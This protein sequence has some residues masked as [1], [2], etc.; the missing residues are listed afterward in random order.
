V[1][2]RLPRDLE[3]IVLK[4]IAKEP[5]RR[6]Q[7]A[8]KMAEDLQR[9]L[10]DRPVQA[11]RSS[12]AEQAWRWGRRNPG[13]AAMAGSVTTLLLIIALGLWVGLVRLEK[14]EGL[15]Q[16]KLYNSL[17]QQALATSRSRR[18]GQRFES[19]AKVAEAAQLARER[20]WLPSKALEL[21]NAALAALAIP[22]IY[23]GRSLA[24]PPLGEG[25]V[26]IDETF[27]LY[28][29]TDPQGNCSIRRVANDLEVHFLTNPAAPPGQ[30][31]IPL[32]I[33]SADGRF[34]VVLYQKGPAQLWQLDG[35]K[36]R[37][38]LAANDV[39]RAFYHPGGGQIAFAYT[40]GSVSVYSL[41]TG[42]EVN[43]FPPDLS[44]HAPRREL[45]LAFHPTKPLLA[46][47]SYFATE[48]QFRNLETG[49]LVRRLDLPARCSWVAW[50]PRGQCLAV[51]DGD[52]AV[53]H[54]YDGTTFQPLRTLSA[55]AGGTKVYF[56][57]AGD[58]LLAGGWDGSLLLYDVP[59]GQ[60]L[61]QHPPIAIYHLR[62]N[63]DDNWLAV[64]NGASRLRLMQVADSREYRTLAFAPPQG[65]LTYGG[66][67]V[68]PA[69]RLLAAGVSPRG[70]P[71]PGLGLWDL[72]T[73]DCLAFLPD[74]GVHGL[75]FEAGP[76]GALLTI[77][78][79][80][81][82]SWPV[83]IDPGEPG[84][85][86]AGSR[87]QVTIGPPARLPLP[88][89]TSL[90][91]SRDGRVLV[92]AA[93]AISGLQAYS[94]AWVVQID[95]PASAQRLEG[96]S[97]IGYAKV[98]PEGHWVVTLWQGGEGMRVWDAANG[99]LIRHLGDGYYP[100]FSPD[101]RWLAAG[102]KD[103][104]LYAVGSW[105]QVGR[106]LRGFSVFSPDA[107]RLAVW[108]L[109]QIIRLVETESGKELA[110][111]EEPN[112]ETPFPVNF[113]P[114]GTRLI[115]VTD[116][117]GR[118]IHVWDLPALR[119]R[120]KKMDLDWDEPERPHRKLGTVPFRLEVLGAEGFARAARAFHH[121]DN[122]HPEPAAAELEKA[123]ALSPQLDW[124]CNQLARLHVLGPKSLRNPEKAV[125]L[126][127]RAIRLC[128]NDI[129]YKNT[130]G[131]AYYRAGRWQSA[132]DTLEASLRD[133]LGWRL[134]Y[135]LFFL[136]MCHHR[137]GDAAKA[138]DCYDRAV[139]WVDERQ[140]RL[141]T[142]WAA[143]LHELR[144]E[145]GALLGVSD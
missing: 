56:N 86:S 119:D 125:A 42:R 95:R 120:L 83:R 84:R 127:E 16:E 90:S 144:Q 54:L 73:G 40:D 135:D 89:G 15:A 139:K 9:F 105:E 62:F 69:G 101:G 142:D 3:T 88:P 45:S 116:G 107:K 50:H 94:G 23:P 17:V 82:F 24:V 60:L 74:V 48:L 99:R 63:R 20:G 22:D 80:G 98:D 79:F 57:H 130:L 77:G 85:V 109:D 49:S 14:A 104:R 58:R 29:R 134:A 35:D 106:S 52:T 32:P 71:L 39:W 123:L 93:R 41:V 92:S 124:A 76:S 110:R 81:A 28:A 65:D 112:L 132:R 18:P 133:S 12:W 108:E 6:Y 36:P 117:K 129:T 141:D 8:A 37:F 87:R 13:W 121:L 31:S 103:A 122:Q 11:R 96:M 59:T 72:D 7:T 19:L 114:D 128:P 10:T 64:D 27:T 75:C 43:H 145:A 131:M 126:A 138:R 4:A 51:T 55:A 1:D 44:P 67:A 34:I 61:F 137:L 100:Q 25:H 97:D 30:G 111:L 143:E 91:R 66:A 118:G 136:A 26:D 113:T 33:F 115:T 53:I 2:R 70:S 47:G 140:S 78:R 5:G 102:G 46:V 21:R 68:H 38:L